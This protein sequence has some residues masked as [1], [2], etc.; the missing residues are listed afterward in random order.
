MPWGF[1]CSV[2]CAIIVFLCTATFHS[3]RQS[4][5]RATTMKFVVA[6]CSSMLATSYVKDID[7]IIIPH[8]LAGAH[9]FVGN[10]SAG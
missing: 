8:L 3:N 1:A 7:I 9:N 10:N 2:V 5:L 4:Y 6:E